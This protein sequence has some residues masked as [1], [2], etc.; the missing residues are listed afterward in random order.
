MAYVE[1][2]KTKDGKTFY[3]YQYIAGIN[4]ATGK[5][6]KKSKR[7]FRTKTEAKRAGNYAE[8]MFKR[9][10]L[11]EGNKTLLLSDYLTTWINEYKIDVKQRTLDVHKYN[12]NHYIIPHV[13]FIKLV[14]YSLQDHQKFINKLYNELNLSNATIRLVNGT[15]N[16]AFKKAVSFGMI[17][18]NPCRGVEFKKEIISEEKN[19]SYFNKEQIS[20]FLEQSKN[21]RE[22]IFYYFFLA[23]IFTGMRKGEL[24]GLQWQN[25]DFDNKT[26]KVKEQRLYSQEKSKKIVLGPP[27]TAAGFRTLSMSDYLANKLKE[28]KTI[29]T[30]YKSMYWFERKYPEYD[31]VFCY[32]NFSPIANRTTNSAF[33]RIS[34]RCEGKVPMM[35]VHDLRHT[36]AVMLREAGVSLEDIQSILGHSN[37]QST[38]I[39]AHITQYSKQNAMAKLDLHIVQNL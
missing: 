24:M 20:I 23:A 9:G 7:G 21:E 12:I 5:K 6:I 2:Y 34:K 36:H 17:A 26:I 3:R 39:Y 27:K 15:V 29:Q 31:F 37:P 16:N 28:L 11:I 4:P 14:D 30:D 19:F 13:G 38:Q 1:A 33:E 8:E 25:I 18:K 10:K 35:N 32:R 22:Y